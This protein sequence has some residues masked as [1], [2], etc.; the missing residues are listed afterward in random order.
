[1]H[2]ARSGRS[3]RNL[4]ASNRCSA[5]GYSFSMYSTLCGELGASP[6][7]SPS[8]KLNLRTRGTRPTPTTPSDDHGIA[9]ALVGSSLPAS[10]VGIPMG[11]SEEPL[12]STQATGD[13]VL[14]LSLPSP[15]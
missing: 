10:G 9:I 11:I 8:Y 3:S 14:M 15:T 13:G 4:R 2:S 7:Y 5:V 1:M 12:S 6:E